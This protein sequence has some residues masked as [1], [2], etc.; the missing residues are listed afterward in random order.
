MAEIQDRPEVSGQTALPE[1]TR[2]TLA[3]EGMTCASCAMRVEKGLRKVAG[4]DNA[5]VNLATERAT[6]TYD[7]SVASADDLIAKVRATGYDAAPIVERAEPATAQSPDHD[8]NVIAPQ[9]GLAATEDDPRA[10][11]LRRR[12]D[13]LILG[14]AL[15]IPVVL[16]S[17]FLMNRF[18]GE[19]LLLLALTAPVW[20]YVGWEFHRA[21]W[22]SA[23]RLGANMD[24]L[25]SLG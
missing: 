9:S 4:V 21:A 17:M 16:L 18:P 13:K 22:R 5:S 2:M 11:D 8:P 15:T 25:V 20:G 10:R 23:R 6:V 1:T 19:N 7:S 14:V 12:R 24:T 3:I